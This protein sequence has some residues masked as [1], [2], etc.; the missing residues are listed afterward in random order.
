MGLSGK[1]HNSIDIFIGHDVGYEIGAADVALDEFEVFETGYFLEVGEAG[2]VVEFV[3]HDYFV[4][5]VFFR[6][7]NGRVRSNEA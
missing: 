7:E 4:L 1:V 6:E 5:R 2:A 3:V